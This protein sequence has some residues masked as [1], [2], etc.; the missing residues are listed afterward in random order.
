MPVYN[1]EPFLIDAVKSIISQTYENWEL[2][3]VDD[4]STDGSWE[5]LVRFSRE[6]KRIKPVKGRKKGYLS[7]SLNLAL[8]RIR[9]KYIAR[10][11]ADDVSLPQ[12]I[13]KQVEFLENNPDILAVGGFLELID[14]EGR[15][16]GEKYFPTDSKEC[17]K[18][19]MNMMPIQ[20]PVLMARARVMKKLRYDT[21]VAKHDDIDIHF[22]LLRYGNFSNIDQVIFQYRKRPNS[23]TFSKVKDVFF[24]ALRVRMRAIVKYGY[25][26]T[27]LSLFLAL[28]E[29]VVILV[30][31]SRS[32]VTLFELV[33]LH[34][35]NQSSTQPRITPA[36]EKTE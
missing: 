34:S 31:P 5:Q 33:R 3:C 2:I 30:L 8:K 20:P 32:I 15:V 11:D 28:A 10:M 23:Y 1:G 26:P 22:Q 7:G 14:E 9:G 17:Y 36:L 35:K 4:R 29:T 24:M 16:I 25:R 18:L 27:I 19:I 13:E 12:R 6:D 21:E